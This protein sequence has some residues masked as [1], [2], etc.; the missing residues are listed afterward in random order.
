MF[1]LYMSYSVICPVHL[2]ME[3]L[4]GSALDCLGI[5]SGFEIHHIQQCPWGIGRKEKLFS[6]CVTTTPH[7]I[8]GPEVPACWNNKYNLY[9]QQKCR[10]RSILTVRIL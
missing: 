8:L 2:E 1:R 3:W 9:V 7:E 5:G 10:F 6:F 4:I